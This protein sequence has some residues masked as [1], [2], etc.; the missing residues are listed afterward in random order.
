MKILLFRNKFCFLKIKNKNIFTTSGESCY[1]T[2]LDL[3]NSII[4][5]T[6]LLAHQRTI[7]ETFPLLDLEKFNQ[8]ADHFLSILGFRVEDVINM[9]FFFLFIQLHFPFPPTLSHCFTILHTSAPQLVFPSHADQQP[10]AT[11]PGQA[12]TPWSFTPWIHPWILESS[13]TRR[14]NELPYPIRDFLIMILHGFRSYGVRTPEVRMV[15]KCPR[16]S[17]PI[18]QAFSTCAHDDV[19]GNVAAGTVAADEDAVEVTVIGQPGLVSAG[20]VRGDPS[21][22]RPAIFV[23]CR[24][25]MSGSQSVFNWYSQQVGLGW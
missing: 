24:K 23:G 19:V 6:I 4:C 10:S 5:N 1:Q 7:E 21:E 20:W 8:T 12:W 22:S 15:K 17:Q 11:K 25:R 2:V 13:F 18:R 14:A 3:V 9:I 16:N